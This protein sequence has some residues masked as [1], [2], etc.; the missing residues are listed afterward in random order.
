MAAEPELLE[1]RSCYPDSSQA[2]TR[3]NPWP[4]LES[5]RPD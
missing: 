4:R 5:F 1:Q 2:E 3:A